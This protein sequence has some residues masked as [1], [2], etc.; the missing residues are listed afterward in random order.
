MYLDYT[1][2]IN[3]LS[4]CFSALFTVCMCVPTAGRRTHTQK[5]NG[6]LER[7]FGADPGGGDHSPD[8]PSTGTTRGKSDKTVPLTRGMFHVQSEEVRHDD[9]SNLE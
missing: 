2:P 5:S 8:C 3:A 1:A 4:V 7:G 6:S 9:V